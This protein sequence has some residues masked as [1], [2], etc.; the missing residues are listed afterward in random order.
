MTSILLIGAAGQL[1][2]EL[3]QTL[4]ALGRVISLDRRDLDLTQ[5]EQVRRAITHYHP[6]LIVNAAAYT[7]VD[8]AECESELAYLINGV[9]PSVMAEAAAN[10]GASLI[11][12]STDYVFN[13]R[14][15]TPYRETDL[16]DPVNVYGRSKLAGEQGIRQ[17]CDR[18]IILRTAWVYGV[19]G[20]SNFV[21]TMLRLGLD[22]KELNVVHDQIG[23]PTWAGDLAQAVVA[24]GL[25]CLF[26]AGN[27]S[28]SRDPSLWGTYHFTNTGTA[29]WY[30]FAVAIF[31]IADQLGYPLQVQQVWPIPTQ[32]Y[33]TL[34]QRPAYSV[35]SL[36]KTSALLGRTPQHWRQS[37]QNM[38]VDLNDTYESA[39]PLWR[40]RNT[41]APIDLHR[42]QT[43]SPRR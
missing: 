14:S 4:P 17:A 16:T 22:R 34:A 8:Q 36:E 27:L 40:K 38:L 7:A 2:R 43:V 29:S 18:H 20:K 11:H 35:L 25:R 3:Q 12:I 13:G 39:Y 24:F 9:A 28:D 30:D 31:D 37:L 41:A 1:G 42:C 6:D 10:I 19:W 26:K 5:T 33:P 23:V 15:H 21:K 32:D